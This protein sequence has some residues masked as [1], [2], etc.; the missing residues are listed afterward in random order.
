MT[1]REQVR[2]RHRTAWGAPLAVA[3][4]AAAAVTALVLRD[5]HG[6]GAWATCPSLLLT[7]QWCPL[8]GSLRGLHDLA[9]GG[10]GEAVGHNLLLL[11][12]LVWLGW[13][14][15]AMLVAPAAGRVVPGPPT[16]ARFCWVL[17]AA[18]A[19]FTVARNLP[20]SPLAP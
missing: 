5:P 4:G 9:T 19:V 1:G 13:W 12:A 16:S 7:G 17:L 20:G 8:C 11:P 10:V 2:V 6:S 15:M 14:W 3:A 18:L